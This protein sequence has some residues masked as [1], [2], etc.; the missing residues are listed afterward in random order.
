MNTEHHDW[1]SAHEQL[2]RIAKER[3]RLDC[4]EGGSLLRALRANVHLH[5]GFASF[6]EY[7]ER[8]FGYSPRWTEER[9]RVAESLETLPHLQSALRD[10]AVPWSTARELTRVATAQS[11]HAWLQVSRGRTLRQVEQLVAGHKPGDEPTD[12]PDPALRRHVLR[13]EGTAETFATFREAM[14][15]LRR[16]SDAPL[17]EDTALLLMSRHVLA[18]P[19]DEGRSSYQVAEQ[20]EVDAA[21]VEMA[22]CDA[23]HVGSVAA[24]SAHVG[25]EVAEHTRSRARQDI[26]P[27]VRRQ[28]LRRDG[29]R[30]VVPGC[31]HGVFLDLHHIVLR[32]E[33][34]D[35]DPDTLI[36]LCAAHHRAQ[37]R[38]QLII[39]GRVSSG[40][41]FRHADGSSYG[42]IA[43]PGAADTY[44]HAFRALCGL[45]FREREARAAPKHVRGQTHVGEP[46]FQGVMREALA[47]LTGAGL[48]SHRWPRDRGEAT[49]DAM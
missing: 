19:T 39:E 33:G 25:E 9:L 12:A 46:D 14:A 10:G 20:L 45:G 32:S 28:V 27:A 44:A 30:C 31:S 11:E 16:E 48:R 4:E 37:H 49:I 5:L 6:A 43:N 26:P 35:H 40:L 17:D 38:G 24:R 42:S 23:Q 22:N 18:G 47:D 7:I 2:S 34:G 36:T 8:L 21:I 41:I 13:V 29:G 3:A 1:Q 15:K